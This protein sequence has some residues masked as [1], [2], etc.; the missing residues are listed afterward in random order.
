MPRVSA[1]LND[2]ASQQG[3]RCASR[4]ASPDALSSSAVHICTMTGPSYLL[5]YIYIYIYILNDGLI[6]WLIL[7][8][9]WLKVWTCMNVMHQ[10][11]YIN[12]LAHNTQKCNNRL[13]HDHI[14][15]HLAHGSSWVHVMTHCHTNS[16]L[17]V[18]MHHDK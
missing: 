17:D 7:L 12:G 9:D 6:G 5:S 3:V 14:L 18:M 4:C 15:I 10:S 2:L 13:F 16:S 1:L 8:F 11:V